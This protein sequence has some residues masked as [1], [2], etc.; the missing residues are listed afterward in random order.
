MG[1]ALFTQDWRRA[2]NPRENRP[3]ANGVGMCGRDGCP[4]GLSVGLL[5]VGVTGLVV[6]VLLLRL[7][8]EVVEKLPMEV[9]LPLLEVLPL[10]LV[11]LA[12]IELDRV[13]VRARRGGGG[14]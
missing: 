7:M 1:N 3:E 11:A 13:V 14:V 5:L 10:L 8:L 4:W 12:A 9:G 6:V 2:L